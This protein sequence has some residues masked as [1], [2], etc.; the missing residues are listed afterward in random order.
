M[1]L[2]HVHYEKQLEAVLLQTT[3]QLLSCSCL[4]LCKQRFH[5]IR[6]SITTKYIILQFENE[7]NS[8]H[9][10]FTLH[11]NQDVVCDALILV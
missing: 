11:S 7:I 4:T 2:L 3:A 8:M 6:P 9:N 1:L 10:D 5:I